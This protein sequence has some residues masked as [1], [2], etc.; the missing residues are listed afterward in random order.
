MFGTNPLT[1]VLNLHRIISKF[2][3]PLPGPLPAQAGRGSWSWCE[4]VP[5]MQCFDGSHGIHPV[6]SITTIRFVAERRLKPVPANSFKRRSAT[7]REALFLPQNPPRP[8]ARVRPRSSIS[9]YENEDDDEDEWED[10]QYRICPS[11]YFFQ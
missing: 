9:D 4:V 5:R 3:S 7:N 6:D 10:C 1:F 11:H 8:R 2:K